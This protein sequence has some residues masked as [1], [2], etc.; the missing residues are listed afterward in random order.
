MAPDREATP[1]LSRSPGLLEQCRLAPSCREHWRHFYA[2]EANGH[3]ALADSSEA[4]NEGDA[5]LL[6]D[7][8]SI[9]AIG[10]QGDSHD[11]GFGQAVVKDGSN[12]IVA[13]GNARVQPGGQ[14]PSAKFN[15]KRVNESFFVLMAVGKEYE[16][17]FH[18]QLPLPS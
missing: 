17:R 6:S 16:R 14:V 5:I 1:K 13:C 8:G 12:E 9:D 11:V 10:A 3:D 4:L 15:V 7:P 18:T 2:I